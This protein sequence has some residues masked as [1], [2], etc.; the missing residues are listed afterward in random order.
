MTLAL[1]A[2]ALPPGPLDDV[3]VILGSDA[4]VERPS[5]AGRVVRVP[6]ELEL[7][8]PPSLAG[9]SRLYVTVRARARL[10]GA[11]VTLGATAEL[12]ATAPARIALQ[13]E[14]TDGE[15]PGLRAGAALAYEPGSRR[16]I[17]VGG[18]RGGQP[19][20]DLWTWDGARWRRGPDPAFAARSDHTLALDARPGRGRLLLH[21]GRGADGAVRGDAWEY[22]GTAWSQLPSGPAPRALAALAPVAD[23]L[24]LSGGLDGRDAALGDTWLWDGQSWR[25]QTTARDACPDEPPAVAS[26]P[27]CRAGAALVSS[28]SGALLLGG[29]LGPQPLSAA[30][31]ELDEVAWRWTGST[32]SALSVST[33]AVLARWLPS[34]AA[35]PG[36]QVL[37]GAG[38]SSGGPRQDFYLLDATTGSAHPILGL[39]PEPRHAAALAYDPARGE[40]LLVGGEAA[41]GELRS[42]AAFDPATA[43]WDLLASD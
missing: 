35:L 14:R 42:T 16:L 2:D 19:L 9:S 31:A 6:S 26:R 29:R 25:E 21:G 36:G 33:P 23:G 4:Q 5:L 43:A 32:W 37:I 10:D 39:G 27:R 3:T 15:G 28:G 7:A 20:A 8:L 13:L 40:A 1:A 18:R 34:A 22:D 41:S 30:A 17:L 12:P 11:K 38:R 24:L